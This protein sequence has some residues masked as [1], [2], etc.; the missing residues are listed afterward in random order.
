MY[1][2]VCVYTIYII[3]FSLKKKRRGELLSF[4]TIWVKLEEVTLSEISQ[5]KAILHDITYVSN[6]FEKVK[7]I[8]RERKK[9]V[10]LG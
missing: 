4:A 8:G 3:F 10:T 5:R 6:L 7:L 1:V 2:C 9:V